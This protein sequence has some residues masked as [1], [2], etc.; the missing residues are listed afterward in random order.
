MI[1]TYLCLLLFRVGFITAVTYEPLLTIG[2]IL[3]ACGV[4]ALSPSLKR[5]LKI[6]AFTLILILFQF[7]LPLLAGIMGVA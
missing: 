2:Y 1:F 3:L 4:F 6:I 5:L 7:A